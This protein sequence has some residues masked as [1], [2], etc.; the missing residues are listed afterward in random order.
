LDPITIGQFEEEFVDKAVGTI[1]PAAQLWNE[2][3]SI[4]SNEALEGN[5]KCLVSI[6]TGV[7]S[8]TSYGSSLLEIGKTLQQRRNKQQRLFIKHTQISTMGID[9]FASTF[10]MGLRVL[11]SKMQHRRTRSWPPQLVMR[12]RK[13]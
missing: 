12:L 9:T 10:P 13:V 1:N 6:G 3:K 4:W 2:A 8:L 7:P 5:I 11:G